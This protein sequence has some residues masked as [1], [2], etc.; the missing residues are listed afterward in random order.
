MTSLPGPLAP[1]REDACSCKCAGLGRRLYQAVQPVEQGACST[2]QCIALLLV[3]FIWIFRYSSNLRG[4]LVYFQ[5]MAVR[6]GLKA[7]RLAHACTRILTPQVP[8]STDWNGSRSMT[9]SLV[10]PVSVYDKAR[11]HGSKQDSRHNKACAGG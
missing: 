5:D 11:L 1:A 3:G 10:Q 8:T 9:R 7:V 6:A 4:L 2:M